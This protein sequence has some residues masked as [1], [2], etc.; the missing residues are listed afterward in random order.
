MADEPVN[1]WLPPAAPGGGPPPRFEPVREPP[2]SEPAVAAPAAASAP[3]ARDRT[4]FVRPPRGAVRDPAVAWALGL[5]IAGLGLLVLSLGTFFVVTV[6]LS[7]AA[8]ALAARARRGTRP[9]AAA[10]ADRRITA[11][12]WLGRIGVFAG[13]AAALVFLVLLAAGFDFE[14]LRQDLQRELDRQRQDGDGGNN[15]RTALERVRATI[16]GPGGR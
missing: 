6:P 10:A 4:A 14:Q 8:W 3:A 13:A 7:A 15:V 9:D 11:A 16:G 12:L 2:R 5:G 1:G